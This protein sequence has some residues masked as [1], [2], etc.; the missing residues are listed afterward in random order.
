MDVLYEESALD[1]NTNKE[2]IK[3]N[4]VNVFFWISAIIGGFALFQ[5]ILFIPS[6]TALV[7][8]VPTFIFGLSAVVLYLS[9]SKLNIS[10]DYVFVSG[11]LRISKVI[12]VN[13]RKALAIIDSQD[14]LQIGDTENMGFDRLFADPN[15]R[16]MVCTP[17]TQPSQDKF[18]MYILVG[19]RE[20]TIYVLECREALLMHILKFARRGVL[21][22]DYVMQ[23][24]KQK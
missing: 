13:K 12:N 11:E 14:I 17:N 16:K 23:E 1:V 19:G 22:T 8:A 20:K 18:F 3:Y 9:K 5:C 24:R 2:K 6:Y 15:T 7:F 21:E 10:Y 4:V